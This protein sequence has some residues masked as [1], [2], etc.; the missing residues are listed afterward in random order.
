MKN[1]IREELK[2]CRII[3]KKT[4]EQFRAAR[5]KKEKSALLPESKEETTNE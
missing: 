1:N 5:K 2:S 4:M 3:N